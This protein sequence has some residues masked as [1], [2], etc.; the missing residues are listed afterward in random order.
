[1]RF[2]RLEEFA[3]LRRED[4]RQ[5]DAIWFFDINGEDGRQIKNHQSKRRV[6]IHPTILALG[7]LEYVDHT[8]PKDKDLVFPELK[9][10]G[11]DKKLGFHFTKWF[12]NY[13]RTVGVYEKGVDYHSFRHNVTTQLF[14]AGLSNAIVDELTGHAG[15]GISQTRYKHQLPLR[16]LYEAISKIDWSHVSPMFAAG[17]VARSAA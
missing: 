8:A 4:V 12:T 9:P 17:T 3:Q 14:A 11:P 7:F 10:G 6:P 16:V 13:R 15:Q 5:E 2:N 1:V